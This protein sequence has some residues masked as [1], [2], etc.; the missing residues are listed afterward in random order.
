MPIRV[1]VV[2]DFPLAREGIVAALERHPEIVVVG[3]AAD[4][5]EALRLARELR[6]DVITLDLWLPGISGIAALDRL[7]AELPG[8]RVLVVSGNE[9][10]DPLLDAIAAG[11][12]GYVSKRTTGPELCDAVLTVHAGG[13]VISPALAPHLLREYASVSRGDAPRTGVRLTVREQQV[14][15]LLSEGLT[16][17]EI[18]E[19]LYVSRRTVQNDLIRIREKTGARRRSELARWAVEHAVA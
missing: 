2:D 18:G 16:D 7:R 19:R 10:A 9:H 14:L 17:R 12:A 5:H 1:L 11:A 13:S 15:R 6:P 8:T 4:G 3:A